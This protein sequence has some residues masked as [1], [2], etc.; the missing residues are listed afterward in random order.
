MAPKKKA[1][2]PAKKASG[3]KKAPAKAPRKKARAKKVVVRPKAP[4]PADL[5]K[6]LEVAPEDVKALLEVLKEIRA[7]LRYM[8]PSERRITV[9][10]PDPTK[11]MLFIDLDQVCYITT[12]SEDPRYAV[13]FVT[14]DGER[15]Y[16]AMPLSRIAAKLEKG[17]PRFMQTSQYYVVNVER[18]TALQYSSARDLWFEGHED[19]VVNA[20]TDTYLN[21]FK[22][23]VDH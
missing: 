4:G 19:P 5:A 7:K 17:N 2:K 23:R 3:K 21:A 10:S 9:A 13:M 14:V 1:A 15:Y 16:S 22:A 18:I 6:D 8:L 20:V 12:K 11:N